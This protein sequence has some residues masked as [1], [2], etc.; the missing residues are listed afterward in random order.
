MQEA[1]REVLVT[2][3][4]ELDIAGAG[5]TLSQIWFSGS[6]RGLGKALGS[7]STGQGLAEM[8][9]HLHHTSGSHP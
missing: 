4:M 8:C 5:I 3:V 6:Q 9:T 1:L 7:S 2:V